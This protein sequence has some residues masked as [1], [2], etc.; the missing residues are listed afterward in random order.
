MLVRG[1]FILVQKLQYAAVKAYEK[2]IRLCGVAG[3]THSNWQKNLD[4]MDPLYKDLAQDLK[5]M[6][7]EVYSPLRARKRCLGLT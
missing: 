3:L 5:R 2:R 1:R 7:D 4:A 6:Q